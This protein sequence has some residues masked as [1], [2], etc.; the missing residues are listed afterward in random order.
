MLKSQNR[1]IKGLSELA[2]KY[3]KMLSLGG[4][5]D[6]SISPAGTS[7][8]SEDP[9]RSTESVAAEP[10]LVIEEVAID[11]E[12]VVYPSAGASLESS[13]SDLDEA[14]SLK[15]LPRRFQMP[16]PKT[17]CRPSALRWIKPC[18]TRSCNETLEHVI[19]IHYS[20]CQKSYSI[21]N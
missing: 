16:A 3:Q 18:C 2:H 1:R 5:L 4:P 20:E 11:K 7:A 21:L 12:A 17:L 10:I 14:L 8:T 6:F 9:P 13:S 15:G 19:T